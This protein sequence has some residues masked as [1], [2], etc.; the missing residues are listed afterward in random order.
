MKP[1]PLAALARGQTSPKKIRV[2]ALTMTIAAV[3]TLLT[4]N[5]DAVI[6]LKIVRCA[7]AST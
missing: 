7:N 5:A 1:P 3:D 6:R 2:D 4:K